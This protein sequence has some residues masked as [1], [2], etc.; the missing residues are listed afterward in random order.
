MVTQK[1]LQ[2][3]LDFTK[4]SDAVELTK[5]LMSGLEG[6]EGWF[7]EAGT[8]LIKNE[9]LKNVIPELRDLVGKDVT[10][11]A[12]LKTMDAGALEVELAYTVSADIVGIS[13]AAEEETI[14]AALKKAGELGIGI[15]IDSISVGNING[16]LDWILEQL[17]IFD[18]KD[19]IS[20]LEYHIALDR[21]SKIRDFTPVKYIHRRCKVPIAVAG[22]LDENIICDISDY[23]AAIFVVGGTI[24]RPRNRSNEEAIQ[25]IR[26]AIYGQK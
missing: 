19:R 3:A 22:G 9:G 2:V 18:K 6:V 23:G 11:V 25:A 5:K 13:G 10:I 12:D 21:Q 17:R 26:K 20:I 14:A 7:L 8:P 16:R 24:V 15:M 4:L 1:S